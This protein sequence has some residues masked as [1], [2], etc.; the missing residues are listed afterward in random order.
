M[1]GSHTTETLLQTYKQWWETTGEKS[2]SEKLKVNGFVDLCEAQRE[3]KA[4]CCLLKNRKPRTRVFQGLMSCI[5][6]LSTST[7]SLIWPM[8]MAAV[9]ASK[10]TG[11]R[12][13]RL[14]AWCFIG[15]WWHGRR[16]Q[17]Y[18]SFRCVFWAYKEGRDLT[19][20]CG[21]AGCDERED[22][23]CERSPTP[24]GKTKNGNERCGKRVFFFICVEKQCAGRNTGLE[25][26][27]EKI[28]W[29]TVCEGGRWCEHEIRVPGAKQWF[30]FCQRSWRFTLLWLCRWN[31]SSRH[32]QLLKLTDRDEKGDELYGVARRHYCRVGL[33][34]SNGLSQACVRAPWIGERRSLRVRYCGISRAVLKKTEEKR[35]RS[36]VEDNTAR[37]FRQSTRKRSLKRFYYKKV[38][39][40]DEA[41]TCSVWRIWSRR[42]ATGSRR[43]RWGQK[44]SGM[45]R[46]NGWPS[47]SLRLVCSSIVNWDMNVGEERRLE[48]A[49]KVVVELTARS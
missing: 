27:I 21:C 36:R 14:V 24:C 49:V 40:A 7:G 35:V 43:N 31:W 42:L 15:S 33:A 2:R 5:A 37:R 4:N 19:E 46:W 30:Q 10:G 25:E 9:S 20:T 13:G 29:L 32:E 26:K 1:H 11:R 41:V 22:V 6:V 45:T 48:Q 18:S 12:K 39:H 23:R 17:S 44:S 28:W 34:S 47:L 8:R 16:R 3:V 38:S